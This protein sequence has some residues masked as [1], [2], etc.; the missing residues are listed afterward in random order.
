MTDSI[1]AMGFPS[2]GGEGLYRNPMS[3]TVEFFKRY[4]PGRFR[5]YNLC[6][7][8]TYDAAKLGGAVV[9]YPCHDLQAPHL[10]M[11]KAFC[12]DVSQWLD[13]DVGNVAA[14]H[15][16]AGRGRTG[17][18]ISCL[19]LWRRMFTKPDDAI[20]FY[21]EARDAEWQSSDDS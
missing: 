13:E 7:E 2:E 6:S 16:K 1:I 20:R 12:E 21:G 4:H 9:R 3:E 15:C 8:K 14:V 17:V 18:L 19:L 10:Y 11:I 5:V